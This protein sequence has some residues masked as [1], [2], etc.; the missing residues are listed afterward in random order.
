[1]LSHIHC[2]KYGLQLVDVP[3]KD[4]FDW[5]VSNILPG[6]GKYLVKHFAIFSEQ[7]DVGPRTSIIFE[8]DTSQLMAWTGLTDLLDEGQFAN[9]Y[10][11][12]P[13]TEFYYSDKSGKDGG[14]N[15]GGDQHCGVIK[16]TGTPKTYFLNDY[17]CQAAVPF[18]CIKKRKVE[19]LALK[20]LNYS[21]FLNLSQVVNASHVQIRAKVGAKVKLTATTANWKWFQIK[22]A[23]FGSFLKSWIFNLLQ[24]F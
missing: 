20:G 3:S 2:V 4:I 9:I 19:S 1:M 7:S 12:R 15:V 14:D 24:I 11:G 23:A 21:G 22:R 10:T 6:F 13:H 8:N 17:D 18:I 16:S 5:I